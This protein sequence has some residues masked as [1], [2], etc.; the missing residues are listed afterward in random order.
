MLALAFC[1]NPH[2]HARTSFAFC[3]LWYL[4]CS[5]TFFETLWQSA[6]LP[7]FCNGEKHIAYFFTT[8]AGCTALHGTLHFFCH[9]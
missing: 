4:A 8:L 7:Q 3:I 5:S 9:P 6:A 2:T 1:S